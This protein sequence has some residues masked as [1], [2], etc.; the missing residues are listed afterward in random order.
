LAQE[1]FRQELIPLYAEKAQRR[2]E[3]KAQSAETMR[4]L[5]RQ[6]KGGV[7]QSDC[8]EQLISYLAD[9]LRNTSGKKQYGYLR[10]ELKNVVDE[11]VDELARDGRVVEAYRLWRETRG[12]I[13]AV[14]TE[15]TSD[16]LPL[17]RCEDFKQVRNM[18]I[19]EA[20]HISDGT[21]TF[22]EPALVDAILPDPEPSDETE[23]ENELDL[24][25]EL[26]PE[27]QYDGQADV[28][29][30]GRAHDP[31]DDS[32]K[33]ASRGESSDSWWT[34]EYL[35]AKQ[36]LFGNEDNGIPQDFKE[37]RILFLSEA[38]RDNPLAMYDL[39]RMCV[40]G[41]GCE[42]DAEKASRWYEKALDGFYAAEEERPWKYTE[43]RIGKMYVAG[44]GAEQDYEQ[45][46]DWLNLSSNQKYKYAQYSLAGLYYQG[47]GVEQDHVQAFSL[48]AS[49]ANQGFP[50][51]SFE[52]G[53]MLRDGIG[54]RANSTRSE[55]AL[56]L[57]NPRVMT[58]S[59]STVSAGCS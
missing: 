43:Y 3:L 34:E 24:E 10:A 5:I 45:A 17:S 8:L 57:W 44:L 27:L 22:E 52:L 40:D 41:L 9:Q 26:E 48:Y 20:M 19:Q 42:A 36:Y 55:T 7:L 53:K 18:V 32:R 50:Y 1:I 12:R 54:C 38:E 30:E 4:E 58:I 49:S 13:E 14:Y 11:I 39:G 31:M 47:K 59:S 51:A 46:A 6:M 37:A 35:L 15:T 2:D 29:P 33:K 16:L 25:G 28:L 23:P 56:L 21:L